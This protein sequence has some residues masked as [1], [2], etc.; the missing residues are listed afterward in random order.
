MYLKPDEVLRQ[1]TEIGLVKCTL[2]T[3]DIFI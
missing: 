1:A 3:K 2:P